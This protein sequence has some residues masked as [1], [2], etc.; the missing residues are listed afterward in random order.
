MK[1]ALILSATVMLILSGCRE[2]KQSNDG[3]ITVDVT[4]NYPKKELI[5][6]YF[7]DVEYIPLETSDEFLCQG[8]ARAIGKNLILVTNLNRV[9]DGNIF[10]FDRNGKALRRINRK[11]QGGEEYSNIMEIILD[12]D[13]D[14]IYVHNHYERKIQ[15]YDLFGNYKRSLRYKENT[16][17]AFYT[18]IVNYDKEHLI[19]YDAYNEDR[20]FVLISK[21]DGSIA[22]KIEIP[23]RE[24][25]IL[26]Q[27]D[28][29]RNS[30][31]IPDP[32]PA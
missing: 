13:N 7:M 31:A 16:D 1:R 14:E 24:T 19:C 15:V 28:M 6:Q 9:R 30:F 25:K 5:L 11:G 12:E 8:F 29:S 17:G 23:V 20:A 22:K 27:I 18:D 21:Q 4:K 10:V 2:N 32:Y 26:R 3:L